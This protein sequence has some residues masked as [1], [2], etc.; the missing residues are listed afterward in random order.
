MNKQNEMERCREALKELVNKKELYFTLRCNKSI[1]LAFQI[2]MVELEGSP[3]TLFIQKQGGWI[4]YPN[5]AKKYKMN[6]VRLDN[7]EGKIKEIKS[8]VE[9]NAVL[10]MHSLPGYSYEEDMNKISKLCAQ[11]DVFLINDCCGSIGAGAAKFGDISVCSF[12]EAKPLSAGGGGF[13]AADSF[14]A[15]QRELLRSA[16]KDAAAKIDFIRLK[17][18]IDGLQERLLRWKKKKKESEQKLKKENFKILN[19]GQGINVLVPFN[20]ESE[21]ERLIKFCVDENLEY[22]ECPRYMRTLERALSIEIKRIN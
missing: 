6:L 21:K 16:E 3:K 15:S 19:A 8:D 9:G 22:V 13:I 4:T 5:Y 2:A 1:E 18:A 11:K 10:I 14:S 12:G 7:P 20:A 17:Q